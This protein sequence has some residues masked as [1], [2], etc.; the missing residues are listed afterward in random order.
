MRLGF[1]RGQVVLSAAVPE[2]RGTTLLVVEPIT[3]VNL[4]ARSGAG[5]GRALVVADHL[6]AGVGEMI[7]IVEGSEAANAYYPRVAPV[8]AYCALIVRDYE[9]GPPEAEAG[10]REGQR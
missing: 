3:S 10:A 1:V 8:D 5:G 2:L 6:S 9:F 4:G 7:G